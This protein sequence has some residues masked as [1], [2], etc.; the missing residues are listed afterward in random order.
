MNLGKK[1][2]IR[3]SFELYK[4]G[5]DKNIL[6]EGGRLTR[7]TFI[8]IVG[9][10]CMLN[11][12]EWIE[13]FINKYNDDIPAVEREAVVGLSLGIF[14]YSKK[15]FG[16]AERYFIEA[17]PNDI[18]LNLLNRNWLLRT[19]Y[20][21]GKEDELE[22]LI[23]SMGKYL[24]RKEIVGYARDIY[25]N[26]FSLMKKLVNLNVYDSEDRKKF[27]N[28]VQEINPM[29]NSMREWFLEQVQ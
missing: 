20:K 29:T 22:L 2:F 27:K 26:I 18:L 13:V 23:E 16:K 4:I 28:N 14:N 6:R 7:A 17:T 19:Y 25:K 15:D 21:L 10:G 24:M 5:L 12:F 9:I 3:E 1:E 11:E 8:N